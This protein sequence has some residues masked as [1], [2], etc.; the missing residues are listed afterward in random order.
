MLQFPQLP[1]TE[2][3]L[4]AVDPDLPQ[5]AEDEIDLDLYRDTMHILIQQVHQLEQVPPAL[6]FDWDR[7]AR[8]GAIA[9]VS[10]LGPLDCA[11]LLTGLLFC[12]P[13][14]S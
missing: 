10:R 2:A 9:R 5:L 8:K 3:F 1:E 7:F 11:P 12:R 13:V 14:T 6:D 4:Q